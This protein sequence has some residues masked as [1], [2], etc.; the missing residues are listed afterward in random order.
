V[1]RAAADEMNDFQTVAIGELGLG[2]AIARHDIAIQF[3][4]H[5]VGLH[6]QRFNQCC[7]S[8]WG[9][10]IAEIA[11]FPIDIEFHFVGAAF[12]PTKGL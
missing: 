10:L 5:A 1:L 4:G 7:Q 11:F 8:K 2:P 12:Q 3:H 6:T 9:R